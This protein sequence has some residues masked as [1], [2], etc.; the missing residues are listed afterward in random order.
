MQVLHAMASIKEDLFASFAEDVPTAPLVTIA[1][2]KLV[3]DDAQEKGRLFEASK[4]LGFF[5]LDMRECAQGEALLKGSD[6]MFD[7]NENFFN[8]P[9]VEKTKYDFAAQGMYFGYKGMGA[10]VVDR[11]DTNIKTEI[12]HVRCVI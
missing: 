8:L 1:L 7:L 4:S 10:E 5:Y 2:R 3:A 6:E 9:I 11:K 12:Y